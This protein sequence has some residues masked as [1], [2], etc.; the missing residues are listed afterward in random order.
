MAENQPTP[1]ASTMSENLHTITVLS[2]LPRFAGEP[3]E[4]ES[5]KRMDPTVFL[6]SVLNYF[7]NTETRTKEKLSDE[8]KSSYSIALLIKLRGTQ[9]TS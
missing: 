3:K 2:E 5:F 9:T 6:R 8:K 7:D 4:G 1:K